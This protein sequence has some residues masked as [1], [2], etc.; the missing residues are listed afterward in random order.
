MT[1]PLYVREKARQLRSEKCLSVNEIAARLAL[2][3]TTV[4]Y[5]VRDLPL[6]RERRS[7]PSQRKGNGAMRMKYRRLRE[8]A[9]ARGLLEYDTLAQ[10]PTFKDFVILYIAEGYKRCRNTVCIAN[11]D[12]RVIAMSASWLKRL[13]ARK[14][15]Y[16]IQYHA[17]QDLVALR[18]HWGNVLGMMAR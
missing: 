3:K 2:P 10:I 8:D 9:Y 11:S 17:D 4:Y 7:S 16:S 18:R 12:E 1:Y 14:L 15:V 5:W 13:A 6:G